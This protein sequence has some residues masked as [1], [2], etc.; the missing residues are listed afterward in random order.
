MYPSIGTLRVFTKWT[1][2]ECDDNIGRM[3]RSLYSQEYFYKPT[4][5]KPLWGTHISIIRG[6]TILSNE[7]KKEIGGL[8]IQFYYIPNIC[9][10]GIHF[11]LPIICPVLDDIREAFGLGPSRVNYHMTIGNILASREGDDYIEPEIFY[12]H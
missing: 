4:I 11:W 6:E 7:I 2:L 5:Q 1:L 12:G 10:N 3:Y 9:T 8:G